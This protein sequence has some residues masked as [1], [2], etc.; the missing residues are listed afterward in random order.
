MIRV[1]NIMNDLF[2]QRVL[3]GFAYSTLLYP[4]TK[5]LFLLSLNNRELNLVKKWQYFH[6]VSTIVLTIISCILLPF[7]YNI[8]IFI[9]F[10][11]VM[12]IALLPSILYF[13][14]LYFHNE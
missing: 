7:N 14:F 3:Q 13:Y 11:M 2:S 12:S 9:I 6:F 10:F 4:D 1:E 5:K 8:I